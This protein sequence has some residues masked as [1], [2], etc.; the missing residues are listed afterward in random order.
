MQSFDQKCENIACTEFWNE[1]YKIRYYLCI[2]TTVKWKTVVGICVVA[3]I[4]STYF[5]TQ[6]NSKKSIFTH[7]I[8]KFQSIL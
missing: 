2:W 1:Q 5:P 8:E 7:T 4:Q 6:L 3:Q